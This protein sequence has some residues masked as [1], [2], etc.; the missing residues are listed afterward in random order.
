MIP[1]C[2]E[3]VKVPIDYPE[4]NGENLEKSGAEQYDRERRRWGEQQQLLATY[5]QTTPV[6]RELGKCNTTGK[7]K[8]KRMP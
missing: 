6:R 2:G 1:D 3:T 5:S 8:N 7:Q 4:K